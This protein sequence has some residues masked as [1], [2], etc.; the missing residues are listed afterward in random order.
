MKQ[1]TRWTRFAHRAIGVSAAAA[2]I[3]AAVPLLNKGSEADTLRLATA[4]LRSRVA[5]AA[6]VARAWDE[7]RVTGAFT[8][9]QAVQLAHVVADTRKE[10][11]D[12]PVALADP[13]STVVAAADALLLALRDLEKLPAPEDA[14]PRS[15]TLASLADSLRAIEQALK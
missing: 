7:H 12:V 11:A 1:A 9:E 2:I 4:D 13:A 3:A 6:L 10:A 14:S 15:R 8:R 5:E